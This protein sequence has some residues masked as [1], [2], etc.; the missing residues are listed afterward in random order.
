VDEHLAIDRMDDHNII[1]FDPTTL[2]MGRRR[3]K[4]DGP[5][6]VVKRKIFGYYGSVR[7]AV[8]AIPVTMVNRLGFSPATART[9]GVAAHSELGYPGE[10]QPQSY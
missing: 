1:L 10:Y 4:E 5:P 6:V 2:V 3:G 8:E 7:A 9:R